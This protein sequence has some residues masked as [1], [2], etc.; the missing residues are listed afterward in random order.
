[1]V[2]SAEIKELVDL[3]ATEDSPDKLKKMIEAYSI[4]IN[5]AFGPNQETLLHIAAQY[6]RLECIRWFLSQ[7]AKILN[8]RFDDP[9]QQYAISL[10]KGDS[11]IQQEMLE[12][13]DAAEAAQ[14]QQQQQQ[15]QQQRQQEH[16]P[17][18]EIIE[19]TGNLDNISRTIE[20][21]I[22]GEAETS[23][24]EPS[25]DAAIADTNVPTK[26]I[27]IE[28]PKEVLEEMNKLP[29]KP[30]EDIQSENTLPERAI[31]SKLKQKIQNYHD[32]AKTDKKL[33]NER[34]R[35]L[36]EI[37]Q[38]AQVILP[39]LKE[40]D[41]IQQITGL[42]KQSYGKMLYLNHLSKRELQND[43]W[44]TNFVFGGLTED[45]KLLRTVRFGYMGD[46]LNLS[47]KVDAEPGN[48]TPFLDPC[49]RSGFKTGWQ[50]TTAQNEN[51]KMFD[52]LYNLWNYEMSTHDDPRSF[53]S[54][55]MW[56]EGK[57]IN[58]EP[59]HPQQA[60]ELLELRKCRF[61]HGLLKSNLA[62]GNL[63]CST[64]LVLN[65]KGELFISSLN[66]WADTPN[67]P[68]IHFGFEPVLFAGAFK[69]ENGKI[70]EIHNFSGHYQPGPSHFKQFVE[71][72]Q[73][74]G[75]LA[76][77]CKIKVFSTAQNGGF[78][79]N[80]LQLNDP[81][82]NEMMG[83]IIKN[84]HYRVKDNNGNA[85]FLTSKEIVEQMGLQKKLSSSSSNLPESIL[86]QRED[87]KTDQEQRGSIERKTV[88]ESMTVGKEL[89]PDRASRPDMAISP[90]IAKRM[91]TYYERHKSAKKAP[92][93]GDSELDSN[94]RN[95]PSSKKN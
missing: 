74:K 44:F 34:Q 40:A 86:E 55:Y 35:L 92:T 79:S 66:T 36:N 75:C 90:D 89:N 16:A 67:H 43:Q 24:I 27:P 64:T 85:E 77:N 19:N 1:M 76:P 53:P 82:Y 28:F 59:N 9:P 7:N 23:S 21:E 56:L 42:T 29:D 2:P 69:V 73:S 52:A 14:Q 10:F 83:A 47:C 20:A 70:T 32:L 6:G 15:L 18:S 25:F 51:K 54:F 8:G 41:E 22:T 11:A 4:D 93:G 80:E 30:W 17:P 94:K 61:E 65:A 91:T 78:V 88:N 46:E 26:A 50:T 95:A 5:T 13:L 3:L 63:N 12:I 38:E 31:F 62:E 48:A 68:H 81:K 84:H 87:S 37:H 49:L 72:M 39:N 58:F 57:K 71:I 33:L 45:H 60:I